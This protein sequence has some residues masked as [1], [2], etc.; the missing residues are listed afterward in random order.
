M[1][2]E[3]DQ[4]I[5]T[6]FDEIQLDH[7]HGITNK[8]IIITTKQNK[9]DKTNKI[10]LNCDIFCTLDQNASILVV[11]LSINTDFGRLVGVV[12]N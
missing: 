4:R 9:I 6:F 7:S 2:T 11:L 1:K 8:T 5:L 3:L 12:T 10:N